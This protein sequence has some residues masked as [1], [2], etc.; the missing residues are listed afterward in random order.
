[1]VYPLTACASAHETPASGARD[2][3][4]FPPAPQSGYTGLYF[5]TSVT[6]GPDDRYTP[7]YPSVDH[8][9]AGSPAEKAGLSK[10]D[11][12]LEVNGIDSR[13]PGSL[14]FSAGGK[15]VLRIR[16]GEEELEIVLTPVRRSR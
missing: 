1:M 11:L 6:V 16:R 12:I 13:K 2:A 5:H 14:A 10:G 8:M 7:G 9:D 4:D 3:Q 15:Y